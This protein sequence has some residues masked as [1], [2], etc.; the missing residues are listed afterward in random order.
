MWRIMNQFLMEI[1]EEGWLGLAAFSLLVALAFARALR[2][3]INGNLTGA[4]V[5]GALA[6]F[7]VSSM[8]DSLLD[9]PR[10]STVFHLICFAGIL[11]TGKT[12]S[13]DSH[14]SS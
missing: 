12:A 9:E 8:F 14:H 11:M 4:A 2:A 7:L 1:S 10:L 13:N 6:A 5:A 3:G